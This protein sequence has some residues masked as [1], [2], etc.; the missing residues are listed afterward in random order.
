MQGH[1]RRFARNGRADA[2]CG[3]CNFRRSSNFRRRLSE[4]IKISGA[5]HGRAGKLADLIAA[6]LNLSLEERQHLLEIPSRQRALDALLPLLSRELEVLKLGSK[7]QNEVVTSMS[8]NQRD[9]FLREQIRAIQRELGEV[10]PG[11][12]EANDFARS[13][14]GKSIFPKRSKK[15]ALKELERLQQMPP[16]VAEYTMTRNYLDW[17]INLPWTKSTED[18][19]DLD[20]RRAHFG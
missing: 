5:Q 3:T 4:Q 18:K 19:L 11:A 7:I 8:K 20:Q 13:N 9:F 2:Q 1:R 14:R 17:I 16:A 6:N 15:V 12:A 10:D